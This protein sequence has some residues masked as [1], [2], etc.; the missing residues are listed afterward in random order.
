MS[1][2]YGNYGGYT[3]GGFNTDGNAGG[4]STDNGIAEKHQSRTSLTPVTIKQINDAEQDVPDGDFKINQ[5]ELNMVSFVGI[6][7]RIDDQTSGIVLKVEDGTGTIDVKKWTDAT[8]STTEELEKYNKELGKYVFVSGALK[9]FNNRKT[10]QNSVVY[11]IVDHNQ[12]L[13]HHLSAI[14]THLKAQG[15]TT[16]NSVKSSQATG[17]FVTD[18]D[19]HASPVDAIYN[20]VKEN[21]ASMP[22]GVTEPFISQ[23][24]GFTT[25]DAHKFCQELVES[26]RIYQGTDESSYFCV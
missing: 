24:L 3:D 22:T 8:T 20:F 23:K 19:A 16:A 9:S 10:V 6:I 5:I 4:F 7:R 11:P 15:I 14:E 21:S 17:L 18:N 13:Y 2:D 12:V 1:S 26:G 25:A